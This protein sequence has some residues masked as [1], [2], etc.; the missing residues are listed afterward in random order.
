MTLSKAIEFIDALCPDKSNG[1]PEELFLFLSRTTPLVN[2]DLLIKDENGRTLLSWR[3]DELCGIGWHIPGGIVRYKETFDER[4]QKT[5]LSEIGT[6][7]IMADAN[8]VNIGQTIIPGQTDR[9][10]YVS[11]LYACRLPEGYKISNAKSETDAGYLKW[12]SGCPEN[13][14]EQQR[15]YSK[16]I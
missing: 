4:L 6:E 12:F 5:A 3:D 1:L 14:I 16:F 10:H 13:L 15:L 9:G 11:F 8:P 2:V 7:V